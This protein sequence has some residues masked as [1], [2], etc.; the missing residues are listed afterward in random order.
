[1]SRA[2]RSGVSSSPATRRLRWTRAADS[3]DDRRARQAQ[4]VA[5]NQLINVAVAEKV[6]ALRTEEYFTE[7]AAKAISRKHFICF[8]V[9]GLATNQCRATNCRRPRLLGGVQR[10]DDAGDEEIQ[11]KRFPAARGPE[12]ERVSDVLDVQI[13][14]IRGALRG[15]EHRQR[16]PAQVQIRGAPAVRG[17][18][19]RQVRVVDRAL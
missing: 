12:D 11:E 10:E 1:V 13:Q 6:S 15:V 7:R 18:Q 9:Q 4:G 3:S 14:V 17:E 2:G 5:L 8:G 19:E 16:L